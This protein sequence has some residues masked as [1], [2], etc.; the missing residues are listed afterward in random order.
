MA[1]RETQNLASLLAG[2]IGRMNKESSDNDVVGKSRDAK[3]CVSREG[4]RNQAVLW[5]EELTAIWSD[6]RRKILRL[7]RECA[8]FGSA[9]R[10]GTDSDTAG[11]ETQNLASL[12]AGAIGRMNKES[13]DNDVIGKSR[14]AKSCI[15]QENVRNWAE[16]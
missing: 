15:S 2:A 13:G 14:D 11:R 8:Q 9:M 4:M 7:T 6:G 12:L 10:R 16:R 1:G 5:D 3:S